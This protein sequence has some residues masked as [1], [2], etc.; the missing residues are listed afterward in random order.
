[1]PELSIIIV[2]YNNPEILENTI[3]SI[4]EIIIFPNKELIIVDNASK[5][6]NV[7]MVRKEFPTVKLLESDKNLGF[8]KACNIG[9]SKAEGEYLLFVNSDITL[10]ENPIPQMVNIFK[11]NKDCGIIG[12]QLFNKD[13]S[14]QPSYFRFPSLLMRFIQLTGLKKLVLYLNSDLRFNKE[15]I[16]SVDFVSGAFLMIE[17]NFF[18][19]IGCFDEDYF[20]YLEDA[21]LCYR[22]KLAG[23]KNLIYNFSKIIHLNENHEVYENPFVF[24]NLN[25]G[26]ILFYRK[27]YSKLKFKVFLIMS[28]LL[29]GIK[30]IYAFSIK[31]SNFYTSELR[32]IIKLYIHSF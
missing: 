10:T 3:R 29:F 7:H 13:G 4:L 27:N 18:L 26:Q 11:K 2:S 12:C 25:K 21:D 31:K 16:F 6:S 28:I 8:S 14:L 22:S 17:R 20:M 9:A 23:K 32:K 1:M 30:Y 5:D 15:T 24:Y 19:K